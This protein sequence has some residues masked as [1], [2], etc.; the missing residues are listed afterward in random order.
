MRDILVVAAVYDHHFESVVGLLKNQWQII[1]D[2]ELV[3]LLE[4][5]YDRNCRSRLQVII[6]VDFGNSPAI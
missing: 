2:I 1:F 6:F 4:D 3:V 5:N